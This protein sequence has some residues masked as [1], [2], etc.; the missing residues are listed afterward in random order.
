MGRRRNKRDSG[1]RVKDLLPGEGKGVVIIRNVNNKI[2][3]NRGKV[4]LGR[5]GEKN[6]IVL[7]G[8]PKE[9]LSFGAGTR[10]KRWRPRIS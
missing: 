9:R 5:D 3:V 4:V 10:L 7:R 2:R 8:N 1:K 6:L